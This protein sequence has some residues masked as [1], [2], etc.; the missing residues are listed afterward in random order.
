[1]SKEE[2]ATLMADELIGDIDRLGDSLLQLE[3][4]WGRYGELYAP[5]LTEEQKKAVLDAFERFGE[6]LKHVADA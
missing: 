6:R 3:D 5:L 1:M 2:M 4:R